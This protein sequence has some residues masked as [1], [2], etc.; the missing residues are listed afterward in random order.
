MET[1]ESFVDR[2]PNFL[3]LNSSEQIDYFVYY[4]LIIQKQEGVKAKEVES[5]FRSLHI[6]PYSN[7]NAY[8]GRFSKRNKSQ[9]FIKNGASYLLE[10]NRKLDIDLEIGKVQTPKPTNDLF[11]ISLLENTRGYLEKIAAQAC[12]CYDLGLYDASLVMTRKLIET[13]I[14]E[15]YEKYGIESR[16][17][18]HDGHYFF[19]K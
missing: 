19:F 14:I 8:L 13:L 2:F 18:G 1:L 17:K 3:K 16:I 12:I 5:C 4:I 7:V 9:K 15:C 10:R 11:P 6:P